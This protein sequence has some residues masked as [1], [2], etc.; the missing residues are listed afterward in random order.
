VAHL[1]RPLERRPAQVQIAVLQ[2]N[3]LTSV[4]VLADLEG[5]SFAAVED[6]G[7]FDLDLDFAGSEVRVRSADE[8]ALLLAE[9]LTP[10]ADS[11]PNPDDPLAAQSF[12][13]LV[14]LRRASGSKTI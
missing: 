10:R 13:Q 1:E 2:P 14:R 6:R 8:L 9:L 5:R 4:A 12:R 7:L 3:L 11:A